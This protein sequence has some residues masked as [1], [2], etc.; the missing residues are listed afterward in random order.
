MALVGVVGV[1]S[2]TACDFVLDPRL[3]QL[4]G[5]GPFGA[6]ATVERDL[7]YGTVLGCDGNDAFC[8]GSQELDVHLATPPPSDG[9]R[10]RHGVLVWLHGGGWTG[11]DKATDIPANVLRQLDRGWDVVSVNYRLSPHVSFPAPLL[12]AKLA[13]RWVKTHADHYGWDLDRLVVIGYSAGGNLAAMAAV[14]SGVPTLEP[15]P[16]DDLSAVDSSVVAAVAMN[17][18]LDLNDAARRNGF[19]HAIVSGYVGCTGC[20]QADLASPGWWVDRGDAPLYLVQGKDDPWAPSKQALDLCIAGRLRSLPCHM[21]LVDT[22]PVEG[23]GHDSGPSLNQASLD[24]FVDR[25]TL[26]R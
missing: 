7:P 21:D 24:A 10:P 18:V 12:D 8:G 20:R 17:G 4:V 1:L 23:R 26:Q 13:I 14:T 3:D 9:S 15:T 16:T 11:G 25:A 22:G 2:M 6:M 19:G 5:T